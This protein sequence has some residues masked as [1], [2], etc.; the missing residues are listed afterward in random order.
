MLGL[1][2]SVED[3]PAFASLLF[4]LG[5]SLAHIGQYTSCSWRGHQSLMLTL[6]PGTCSEEEVSGFSG[7]GGNR[8]WSGVIGASHRG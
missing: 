6:L 4:R 8:M 5:Y 3:A 7:C 2:S 1:T